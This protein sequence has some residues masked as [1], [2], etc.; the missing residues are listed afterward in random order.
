MI[1]SDSALAIVSAFGLRSDEADGEPRLSGPVARGE[2]GQVWRLDVAARSF[3]MKEPFDDPDGDWRAGCGE[4]AAFQDAARRAGV[5][6]PSIVRTPAGAVVAWVDGSPVRL[7]EWVELRDADPGLDV[8]SVGSMLATLHRCGF[9]GRRPAHW[10]Y[11]APVGAAHWDEL[12][13]GVLRA[14]AP[15]ADQVRE[16]RD[17]W[18]AMEEWL[19]DPRVLQT[20]H[21]D[22]WAD[23]VRSTSRGELCVID[24]ENVGLADPSGELAMVLFEF[25]YDDGA[26]ARSLVDAYRDAGGPGRVD[27]PGSF[28]MVIAQFG[29]LA[30]R[31]CRRW[32]DS[33]PDDP[34]RRRCIGSFAEFVDKPHSRALFESIIDSVASG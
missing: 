3:A 7:Y 18:V 29:H 28:T 10:W 2:L 25:A 24:W 33:R 22:V 20:C 17:E 9:A 16:C 19:E 14:G 32:I 26:R 23:N 8:A 27:H 21:R 1:T 11:R 15:F 12:I 34:D 31:I 4:S 5:P 6:S 30:E 13:E